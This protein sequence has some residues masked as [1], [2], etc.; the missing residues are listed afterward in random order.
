MGP[1]RD[2]LKKLSDPEPVE[3]GQSFDWRI[4]VRI[5]VDFGPD[6]AEFTIE[7]VF[8]NLDPPGFRAAVTSVGPAIASRLQVIFHVKGTV[9]CE[10]TDT[11]PLACFIELG[12]SGARRFIDVPGEDLQ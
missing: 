9:L 11:R 10:N 12:K 2:E 7:R 8:A 6:I 1:I 3:G 4:G 5:T